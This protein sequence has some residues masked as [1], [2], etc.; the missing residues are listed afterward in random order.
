MVVVVSDL[1]LVLGTG[2]AGTDIITDTRVRICTCDRSC[3]PLN[4]KP[5]TADFSCPELQL[6]LAEGCM[7]G[8]SGTVNLKLKLTSRCRIYGNS[9]YGED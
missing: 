8:F 5:Y 4:W 2:T 9:V 6:G 1:L 7:Q 3:R